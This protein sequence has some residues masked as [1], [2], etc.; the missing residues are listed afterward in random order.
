[1]LLILL[2]FYYSHFKQYS[3][4]VF[5]ISTNLRVQQWRLEQ[6]PHPHYTILTKSENL[7]VAPFSY[8]N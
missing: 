1:M 3:E 4:K 7:I 5:N 8:C 2:Q 6:Y